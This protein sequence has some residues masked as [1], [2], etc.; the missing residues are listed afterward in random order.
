M[1]YPSGV[2]AFE[3]PPV[4]LREDEH[5][6][7]RVAGS[8]VT[9]DSIVSLFERGATAEEVVQSFPTL[10]LGDVYVV[11]SYIL[12]RRDVVDAYLSRRATEEDVARG[13]AEERSPSAELRA[14]LDARRGGVGT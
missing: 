6:V 2:Q 12:A 3:L 10:A 14:R 9:L 5:G 8:R 13:E 4:P 7:I 11:L 1:R